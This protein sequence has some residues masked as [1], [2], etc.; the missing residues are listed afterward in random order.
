MMSENLVCKFCGK[1]QLNLENKKFSNKE[2]S[3]EFATLNCSCS[4][5]KSYR[6][7]INSINSLHEFLNTTSFDDKTKSYLHSCGL[8][9]LNNPNDILIYQFKNYKVK[10][11]VKDDVLKVVITDTNKIERTF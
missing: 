7:R 10:F 11:S 3:I 9:I 2:E 6:N 8:R 4:K 5:G 1:S